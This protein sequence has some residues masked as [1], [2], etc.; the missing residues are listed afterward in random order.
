MKSAPLKYVAR[1]TMLRGRVMQICISYWFTDYKELCNLCDMIIKGPYPDVEI[2]ETALTPLVL[3]R[4]GELPDKPALI[5]GPSGRTITYSQL[6]ESIAIAAY[7]LNQG[8]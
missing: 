1:Q 6:A 2:P 7:N 5:D 4:A 8:G 3:R